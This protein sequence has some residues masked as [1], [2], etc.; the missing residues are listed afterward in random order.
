[1]TI[2]IN[3]PNYKFADINPAE[4]LVKNSSIEMGFTM[5]IL[6]GKSMLGGNPFGG[7]PQP[8]CAIN[9]PAIT[10][11]DVRGGDYVPAHPVIPA[12][13]MFGE[14]IPDDFDLDPRDALA[15]EQY[16]ATRYQ[17]AVTAPP[18][19]TFDWEITI[20]PIGAWGYWRALNVSPGKIW[21]IFD[22]LNQM[23][24]REGRMDKVYT[25]LSHHFQQRV[26]RFS[27]WSLDLVPT[28]MDQLINHTV[29][30]ENLHYKDHVKI[31]Q[32]YFGRWDDFIMDLYTNGK[33]VSASSAPLA[34]N[35]VLLADGYLPSIIERLINE[36]VAEFKTSGDDYHKTD[37]GSYPIVWVKNV[38]LV[39][40]NAGRLI[41]GLEP[42][43]LL[44]GGKKLGSHLEGPVAAWNGTGDISV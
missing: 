27:P 26:H 37:D 8:G 1:M 22:F 5:P 14:P 20:P 18:T 28:S 15:Q 29:A 30:H 33:T 2:I 7:S 42:K 11:T 10:V 16:Q 3:A 43:K 36:T 41:L 34:R 23:N 31:V 13:T 38:Q 44:M 19:N 9:L 39:Q 17:A 6:N 32:A 40:P 4:S 21:E 12:V 35:K 25:A 24:R